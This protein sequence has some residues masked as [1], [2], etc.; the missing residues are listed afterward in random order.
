MVPWRHCRIESLGLAAARVSLICDALRITSSCRHTL[1]CETAGAEIFTAVARYVRSRRTVAPRCKSCGSARL[2]E[3]PSRD[4]GRS[5]AT[6]EFRD[7]TRHIGAFQRSREQVALHRMDAGGR[8]EFLVLDG[9]DA[10]GNHFEPQRAPY[11]DDRVDDRRIDGRADIRYETA[12]DLDLVERKATKRCEAGVT[13]TKIVE[14]ERHFALMQLFH[15][16]EHGGL[17]IE[18]GGLGDLELDPGR[19]DPRFGQD[20]LDPVRQSGAVK[21]HRRYV[22]G[23]GEPGPSERVPAGASQYPFAQLVNESVSL[24]LRHEDRRRHILGAAFPPPDES[25]DAKHPLAG[26]IDDRLVF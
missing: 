4:R 15:G 9:L 11:A 25:F 21:L 23:D 17:G 8:D 12:I 18:Q 16:G 5:E 6:V 3:S 19:I 26:P 2:S 14:R 1:P 13:G 20:L 10:F 22:D 7:E 24:G